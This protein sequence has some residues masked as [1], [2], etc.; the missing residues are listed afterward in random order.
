VREVAELARTAAGQTGGGLT[1]AATTHN[2]AALIAS[3]C[4]LPDLARSLCW[5]Q[6]DVYLRARPLGAQAA[7]YTLEPIANLAR[8][9]IRE[10]NGK[11]PTNCS[12]RCTTGSGSAQTP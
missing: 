12:T 8:L 6:F 9:L 4:G 3:D 5:Q 2:K 11:A 1:L 7:R 10:G